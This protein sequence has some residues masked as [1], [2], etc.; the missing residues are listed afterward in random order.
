MDRPTLNDPLSDNATPFDGLAQLAEAR[1]LTRPPVAGQTSEAS[2]HAG[3]A[4]STEK[5]AMSHGDAPFQFRLRTM[6]WLVVAAS[7]LFAVMQA[8][9]QFFGAVWLAILLWF[10]VLVVAHVTANFWG[11]RI[12]PGASQQNL[13]EEGPN[14]RLSQLGH[15]HAA[16]GAVRLSE[17]TRPGWPMF[18]FTA[19]GALMGGVL[20]GA[21]LSLLSFERAGYTGVI[22]GTVSAAIVGG[23]LGFLTSTFAEIALR[24]WNEAVHGAGSAPGERDTSASQ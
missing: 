23:F 12:A 22:V 1:R 17:S 8:V 7:G 18:V 15:G 2:E 16:V 14:N 5:A 3:A 4:R 19:V 21:S 13:D 9:M 11:T 24:A 6:L 20:G 10:L